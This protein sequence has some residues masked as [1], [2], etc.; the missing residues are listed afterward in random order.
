M[1]R[2]RRAR[3]I[4]RWVRAS[5]SPAVPYGLRHSV[6]RGDSREALADVLALAPLTIRKPCAHP[7]RKT[8]SM[9]PDDS[10]VYR[11]AF[12]ARGIRRPTSVWADYVPPAPRP[13]LPAAVFAQAL[14]DGATVFAQRM[15]ADLREL[16]FR[17]YR[18]A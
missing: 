16:T 6:A 15:G 8:G 17:L 13:A 18:A 4:T 11:P 7:T 5:H 9:T 1:P 10:P 14:G 2:D 3:P 12:T